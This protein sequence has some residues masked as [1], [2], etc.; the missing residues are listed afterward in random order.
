M[1]SENPSNEDNNEHQNEISLQQLICTPIACNDAENN[2]NVN[3]GGTVSNNL[4][5]NIVG[6]QVI[7]FQL[8]VQIYFMNKYFV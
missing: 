1:Y 6:A 5:E 2:L 3:Y 7:F 4:N 8:N